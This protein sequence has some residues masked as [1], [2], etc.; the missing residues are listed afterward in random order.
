VDIFY[1]LL[2]GIFSGVMAGLLGIG[3]GMIIVP[4]L[5][6]LFQAQGIDNAIVIKAAVGTSLATIIV[7]GCSSVFAHH[8][9]GAVDWKI[10][11]LM[12]PGIIVGSMLGIVVA[13]ILP[14][15]LHIIL[16]SVFIF[17]VAL[18]FATGVRA[19]PHRQFLYDGTRLVAPVSIGT[20]ST[21]MGIGGGTL[22]VPYLVWNS[23]VMQRAVATA[24]ALG[25]PIA[26]TGTIG[27]I[28]SGWQQ[29][30]LP[31]GSIGYVSL[32][33]F[34]AIVVASVVA[35]PIGAKVAHSISA[36]LLKRIFALFLIAMGVLMLT[37]L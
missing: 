12:S 9:H 8:C 24:A 4:I 2:T 28:V 32:P 34:L 20:V 30:G 29:Q 11:K 37:S 35:A 22:S 5:T 16:F 1:L 31:A 10:F 7:T 36:T 14:G 23:I 17:L 25:L 27:F 26:L 3:G 33:A 21:I 19:S 15:N 6:I 18:Q 13:Y